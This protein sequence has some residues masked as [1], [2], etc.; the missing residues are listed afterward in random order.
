MVSGLMPFFLD[1]DETNEAE[2]LESSR[3]PSSL[4]HYDEPEACLQLRFSYNGTR[5]IEFFVIMLQRNMR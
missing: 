2:E 4:Q 5:H 3:A 1:S